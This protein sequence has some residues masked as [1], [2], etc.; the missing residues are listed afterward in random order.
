MVTTIS[1]WQTWPQHTDFLPR[2]VARFQ[3]S[4]A[5]LHISNSFLGPSLS[6]TRVTLI[7]TH[8]Q[9]VIAKAP[10]LFRELHARS[11]VEFHCNSLSLEL[12]IVCRRQRERRSTHGSNSTRWSLCACRQMKPSYNFRKKHSPEPLG[13]SSPH[14]I[15]L[16]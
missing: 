12:S 8:A 6:K 14:P 16:I 4:H 7:Q 9:E 10:E 15:T 13:V 1:Q 3:M 11:S 5:L 2:L